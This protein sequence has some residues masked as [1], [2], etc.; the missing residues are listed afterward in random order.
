VAA[1]DF[2]PFFSF[3]LVS[4]FEAAARFVSTF[5]LHVPV[6]FVQLREAFEA[7]IMFSKLEQSVHPVILFRVQTLFGNK[8]EKSEL[9]AKTWRA[10]RNSQ[11]KT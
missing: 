10:H 7:N 4:L 6:R 3:P 5:P 2:S 8:K 11:K 9:L 1:A